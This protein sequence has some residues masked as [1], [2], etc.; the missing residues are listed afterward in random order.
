M[1]HK[2]KPIFS[3]K[4]YLDTYRLNYSHFII[5]VLTGCFIIFGEFYDNYITKSIGWLFFG[6]TL[7]LRRK[8]TNIFDI[9]WIKAPFFGTAVFMIILT[10]SNRNSKNFLSYGIAFLFY[11]IAKIMM[12]MNEKEDLE[13]EDITIYVFIGLIILYEILNHHPKKKEIFVVIIL[14]LAWS[15]FILSQSREKRSHPKHSIYV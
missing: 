3:L 4:K 12:I 6:W 2:N 14:V 7:S 9:N 8:S 11:I 13:I 1:E 15:F 10:M 5:S